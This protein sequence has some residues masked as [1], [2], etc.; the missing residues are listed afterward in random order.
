MHQ[1]LDYP[2]RQ[3]PVAATVDICVVGGSCTGV[4]AALRAARPGVRV[5]VVE[6][7]NRF[8]GTATASQVCYWH[9]FRDWER[10]ELIIGGYTQEVTRRLL[11]RGQAQLSPTPSHSWYVRLNTEELA[12][13][14]DELVSQAGVIP[15][16]HSRMVDALTDGQGQV[17]AVVIAD[18]SGL[19]AIR[20]DVFIDASG[21]AVLCRHAGAAVRLHDPLQPPTACAKFS[22]WPEDDPHLGELIH[23]NAERLRL[24]EGFVWGTWTPAHHT[25]ML[26]ATKVPHANLADPDTLTHAEIETRRQLRAYQDLLEQSGRRRPVLAALP[27]LIGIRET[28]HIEALHR[29]TTQELLAGQPF[30]DCAGRG[31]Y[32]IDIHAQDRAGTR[33]LYLDGTEVFSAPGQPDAISHWRDPALPTPPCYQFPIRSLIPRGFRNLIAA[34]RMLD[35]DEGAYG[36]LRVMV[37]LNQAGESAGILAAD[38]LEQGTAIPDTPFRPLPLDL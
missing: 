3:L 2:A 24:P 33:F 20:A 25:Y 31:T 1:T 10:R 17:T 34:G 26:A 36:A 35:A 23:R 18:Q 5:A 14:L 11:Q 21:D 30:D 15:F 37:N 7:Q 4:F 13:E 6:A 22:D 19:R 29:V 38:A 16:L 28:W 27:S 8:G 32:R 12:I 9:D